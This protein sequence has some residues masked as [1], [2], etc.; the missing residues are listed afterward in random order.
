MVKEEARARR[1]EEEKGTT[2]LNGKSKTEKEGKQPTVGNKN[3]E[4]D[5]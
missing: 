5:R 4:I 3:I 2:E 1:R